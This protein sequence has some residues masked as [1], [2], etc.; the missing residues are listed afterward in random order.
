MEVLKTVETQ[1]IAG[2]IEVTTETQGGKACRRRSSQRGGGKSFLFRFFNINK[3][4]IIPQD[5][6]DEVTLTPVTQFVAPE[7]PLVEIIKENYG[8]SNEVWMSL[9]KAMS[10]YLPEL[11]GALISVQN[12]KGDLNAL[13]SMLNGY[14][15]TYFESKPN[16]REQQQSVQANLVTFAME[17]LLST[18]LIEK[19]ILP[20]MQPY[21]QSTH[22]G[23]F[24]TFCDAI[25]ANTK[26][27]K[28]IVNYII[29]Y[30]GMNIIQNL[31]GVKFDRETLDQILPKLIDAYRHKSKP[32]S[33]NTAL[34]QNQPLLELKDG[35]KALR[36]LVKIYDEV[37]DNSARS[38]ALGAFK[39]EEMRVFA[40]AVR[41]FPNIPV[42]NMFDTRLKLSIFETML[43]NHLRLNKETV[44]SAMDDLIC[45]ILA[46]S[47]AD[48]IRI[49]HNNREY[50]WEFA[51]SEYDDDAGMEMN[52]MTMTLLQ[53]GD[54]GLELTLT[55]QPFFYDLAGRVHWVHQI[56]N[57]E[58]IVATTI[59]NNKRIS[60]DAELYSKVRG[61]LTAVT[62]LAV[63]ADNTI[64]VQWKSWSY[65][66]EKDRLDPT[67]GNPENWIVAANAVTED[68]DN[69]GCVV[70][71]NTRT[72]PED[73]YQPLEPELKF[74]ELLGSTWIQFRQAFLIG[75]K[76]K[77]P[78]SDE[79][80]PLFGTY[81]FLDMIDGVPTTRGGGVK[82]KKKAHSAYIIL[83]SDI[84]K[85][86]G[87]DMAKKRRVYN[88][89]ATGAKYIKMNGQIV[90][91]AKLRGRYVVWRA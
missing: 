11:K 24:S 65:L 58:S 49:N 51:L 50:K 75:R 84:K 38:A 89:A 28:D 12:S 16:S 33:P 9:V 62:T 7:K 66:S 2:I 19:E 56:G 23:V 78:F 45:I 81:L 32:F 76:M 71:T 87:Q 70:K 29:K 64:Q 3:G 35:V 82:K 10:R 91:L 34:S 6:R 52:E 20:R 67:I 48:V 88:D 43:D 40:K 26:K 60:T 41:Q 25:L 85:M 53:K 54:E 57:L 47:T 79:N 1:Y 68:P 90:Q 72:N 4:S 30:D 69:R 22:I 59:I 17:Q 13:L 83:K 80:D 36:A 86:R 15:V 77:I 21:D 31:R 5:A 74:Q 18:D 42:T 8:L 63:P 61:L 14:F 46:A 55:Y 73:K 39:L 37:R 44:F 27:S